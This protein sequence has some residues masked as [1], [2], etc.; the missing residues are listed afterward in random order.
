MSIM[1][2]EDSLWVSHLILPFQKIKNQ[3]IS[4]E[5]SPAYKKKH[6]TWYLP[7]LRQDFLHERSSK[8]STV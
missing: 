8:C 3:D 7:C 4:C 6:T 1:L 2:N 5:L